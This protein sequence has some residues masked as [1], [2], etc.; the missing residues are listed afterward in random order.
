MH[1]KKWEGILLKK[2]FLLF[3]CMVIIGL[4]MLTACG[5][6]TSSDSQQNSGQENAGQEEAV[7]EKGGKLKI[8]ATNINVPVLRKAAEAYKKD[9]PNF[10]LEAI[11][12]ANTDIDTKLKIG[13]QAG[14]EGLPDAILLVDDG[15]QGLLNNFP[16]S[17]VNLS[18]KG[19]DEHLSDFPQYKIDSVSKDGDVYAFPFDAGPVGVFYRTD[20]FEEAG[21]DADQIQTWDDYIEAGKKIKEKTGVSMLS[22]DANES[23]VYT[24]LLSQ[25]G[26]GYFDENGNVMLGTEESIKASTLMQDLAEN[27]LLLGTSGWSAW[28]GSLKNDQT[29]TAIA[30]AWLIGTLQQQLPDKS[31]KWGVMPL[32]AF[33]EGG[34]RAANQGGS[35]FAIS[36]A[37]ENI[38][39]AYDFLTY[40]T[41]TF[42]VQEIAMEGGLFPTYSPVYESDLFSE[43][44]AY[45]NNDKV[46]Q[47]F[48]EQMPKIPS[49]L[50]TTHDA[51]ARDEA[52]KSQAEVVNGA[53]VAESLNA[54]KKRVEN[55]IQ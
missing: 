12:M 47:F 26:L 11:E 7:E 20:I 6:D 55:R 36:K 30:G 28:V 44:I 41:T 15:I 40:F 21:V 42:K 8:W 24:V 16:D 39:L 17:F 10:E 27:D 18:E 50:Y 29:A 33:E 54:A 35:S 5:N 2:R 1:D 22:Y 43:P 48:A 25:Q 23:T 37:S 31:G 38:D 13:L 14:G 34:S 51:V 52:I 53:D 4:L 32:P 3:S 46:W 19:F 49:I 45:F 9:H